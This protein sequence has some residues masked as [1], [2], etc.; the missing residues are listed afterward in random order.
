MNITPLDIKQ[1]QFR[2]KFRGFDIREVDSFLEEVTASIEDMVRENAALRED[3]A[4]LESQ[5]VTYKDAEKAL[6]DTLLAAQKMAEDMKATSERDASLR[7]KEAELGA[8]KILMDAKNQLTRLEEEITELKRLKQRFTLKVRGV[9]D[10]HLKM[11]D[12]EEREEG[13]QG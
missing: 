6:R 10:D 4:S 11:L 12:Y 3:K 7:L 13:T 9:I 8:E 2:L 5:L 1:R